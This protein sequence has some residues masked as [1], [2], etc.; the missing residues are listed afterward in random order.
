MNVTA[1]FQG[2][3]DPPNRLFHVSKCYGVKEEMTAGEKTTAFL[4]N[5]IL[6][7][8]DQLSAGWL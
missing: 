1:P 5:G 4:P 7:S 3:A 8:L 6:S 2:Y